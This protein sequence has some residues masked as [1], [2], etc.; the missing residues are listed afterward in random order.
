M[1]KNQLSLKRFSP[2]FLFTGFLVFYFSRMISTETGTITKYI[3]LCILITNVIYTDIALWNY[4]ERKKGIIWIVEG[5]I[6]A[7][8]T[9]CLL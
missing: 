8:L 2:F 3:L 9:Y 5:I 7:L 1:K 6:S 4:F